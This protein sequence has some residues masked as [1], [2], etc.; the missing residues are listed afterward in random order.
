MPYKLFKSPRPRPNV[1]THTVLLDVQALIIR[2]E[3]TTSTRPSKLSRWAEPASKFAAIPRSYYSAI[4]RA[5]QPYTT[6][7]KS[8]VVGL[9]PAS[10]SVDTQNINYTRPTARTYGL[11]PA[12][13][14]RTWTWPLGA[15]DYGLETLTGYA[16]FTPHA[17]SL[18]LR[19]SFTLRHTL[20]Q[21][22]PQA[23]VPTSRTAKSPSSPA[24]TE[25][26][27]RVRSHSH[28]G[29]QW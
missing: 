1:L 4:S 27:A 15:S 24:T 19:S 5:P 29:A 13:L 12:P 9:A 26:T 25:S 7:F 10:I 20:P 11:A 21:P 6:C 18:T 14:A 28:K 17:F 16:E 3:W 2:S 8:F 23:Q 22:L